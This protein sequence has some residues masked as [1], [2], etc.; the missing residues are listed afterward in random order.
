MG[1]AK[2][3]KVIESDIAP[4]SRSDPPLMRAVR[5]QH[6]NLP[7]NLAEKHVQGLRAIASRR[8]K[9]RIGSGSSGSEIA[10]IAL[11]KVLS[12][13]ELEYDV[14]IGLQHVFACE[15]N[16][17]VQDFILANHNVDMM[18]RDNEHLAH[19]RAATHDGTVQSA[20]HVT[21]FSAGF[22][23]KTYSRLRGKSSRDVGKHF[24]L[25]TNLK[26]PD[27]LWT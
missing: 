17:S 23:C 20:P 5:R 3:P 6:E 25:S 16:T 27:P 26:T 18:F 21:L 15:S 12:Y 1:K 9:L 4:P 19:Q 24:D 7:A 11:S 13:A 8:Q 2:Y 10:T 22:T 14:R